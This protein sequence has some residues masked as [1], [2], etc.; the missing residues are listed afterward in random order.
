MTHI[1]H[2]TAHAE[3]LHR[4]GDK[5][6]YDNVEPDGSGSLLKAYLFVIDNPNQSICFT[7]DHMNALYMAC[8]YYENPALLRSLTE[9]GPGS[10]SGHR[11]A[12][13]GRL[14]HSQKVNK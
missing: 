14:T 4:Q 10:I 5:S 9:C 8:R 6:L 7:P 13:F 3:F 11:L 12:L 2:I 1:E